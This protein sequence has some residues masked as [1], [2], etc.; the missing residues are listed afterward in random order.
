MVKKI[1]RPY[2]CSKLA[3]IIGV[4]MGDGG[5]TKKQVRISLNSITDRLYVSYLC[6]PPSDKW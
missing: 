4:L 6:R 3:E 2:S 5:I 1:K